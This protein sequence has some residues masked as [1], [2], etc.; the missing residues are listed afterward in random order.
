LTGIMNDI[1]CMARALLVHRWAYRR[2]LLGKKVSDVVA[3]QCARAFN[4]THNKDILDSWVA[5]WRTGVHLLENATLE[6][7]AAVRRHIKNLRSMDQ[8][9]LAKDKENADFTL[10]AGEEFGSQLV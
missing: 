9:Q 3:Y 6:E 4:D 8:G 7:L 5:E 1:D 2:G 10:E